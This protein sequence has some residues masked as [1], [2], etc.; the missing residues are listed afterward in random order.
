MSPADTPDPVS[1]DLDSTDLDGTDAELSNAPY[2]DPSLAIE[3]RVDDLIARMTIDERLA[4]LGGVWSTGLLRPDADGAIGFSPE[5]AQELLAHGTGQVTRIAASTGL[6]PAG[7]ARLHNQIQR[8]LVEH[9][10]LGIPAVLHEE[11]VAGL[12]AR[13]AVQF[14]QAIGLASTW[15]RELLREVA[16]HVRTEML[17]IGARQAL[18]PVLDIARDP[19]WGRVEETY[20]EDPV[21]TG[22]LGA[23]FVRGLQAVTDADVGDVGRSHLRNG[24]IAT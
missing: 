24:V 5:A 16:D 18:S 6:R 20:G 9:T 15:D 3:E 7:V 14:P 4:Q 22:T 1:T 10:R 23:A 19:R 2:R 12:C 11:A 21:L 13:D 8:W 17:A